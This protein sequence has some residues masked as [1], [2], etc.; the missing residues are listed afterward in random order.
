MAKVLVAKGRFSCIDQSKMPF[1]SLY[2]K[3]MLTRNG[4]GE[5]EKYYKTNIFV[6]IYKNIL[7]YLSLSSRISF[8]ISSLSHKISYHFSIS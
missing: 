6:R 3:Q 7:S 2:N 4:E 8:F 5:M 1:G